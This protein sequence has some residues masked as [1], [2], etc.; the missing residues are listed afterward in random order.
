MTIVLSNKVVFKQ[1]YYRKRGTANK[2]KRVNL[3]GIYKNYKLYMP[4]KAEPQIHEGKTDRMKC[5]KRHLNN[6]TW[7]HD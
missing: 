3:L 4:L 5:R 7:K 6:N 2:D 1:C